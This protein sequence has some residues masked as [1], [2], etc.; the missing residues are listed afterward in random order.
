MTLQVFQEVN[1][2][3][4]LDRTGI[5]AEVKVPPRQPRDGGELLPVEVELQNRRLAFGTPC[6]HPV[7]LL[8]QSALV[9]KEE[10][11]PFFFGFFLMRGHSTRFQRVISSSLRS[12]ARPVG[13]WQLQ[14]IC[15]SRRPTWSR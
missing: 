11:A 9:D 14:P 15:P 1:H 13:R 4:G 7:R 12:R 8:A 6:A 10:S 3:L 5:E 2:L